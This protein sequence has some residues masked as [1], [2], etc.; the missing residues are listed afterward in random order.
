MLT[1]ALAACILCCNMSSNRQL[2]G[3][4]HPRKSKHWVCSSRA[5]ALRSREVPPSREKL[6]GG[7]ELMNCFSLVFLNDSFHSVS[8]FITFRCNQSDWT[9]V[10]LTKWSPDIF[11]AR[12]A[13]HIITIWLTNFPCAVSIPMTMLWPPVH[14]FQSLHLF[15]PGPWPHSPLATSSLFSV[16]TSPTQFPTVAAPICI[17]TNSPQG[18]PFLHPLAKTCYFWSF[19]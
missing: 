2:E 16:S 12:P 4:G 3:G 5:V 11:S 8:C 6:G 15:R 18:F 14:T 1:C 13:P 10:W 9:V 17:P 7:G 19:R